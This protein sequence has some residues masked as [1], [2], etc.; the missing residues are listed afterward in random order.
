MDEL[1]VLLIVGGLLIP[2]FFAGRNYN[3][4]GFLPH[5]FGHV[6]SCLVLIVVY[7][8]FIVYPT[9][10]C[11]SLF[12][13]IGEILLFM[14]LG[15]SS[16]FIWGIIILVYSK[17]PYFKKKDRLYTARPKKTETTKAEDEEF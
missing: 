6:G 5:F 14:I 15:G 12:C 10:N 1:F 7:W 13:G 3:K 8:V 4:E 11:C 2:W 16:L 17:K 9:L